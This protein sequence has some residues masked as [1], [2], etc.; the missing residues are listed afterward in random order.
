[1]YSFKTMAFLANPSLAEIVHQSN[2]SIDALSKSGTT[3][4]ALVTFIFWIEISE[5]QVK[6]VSFWKILIFDLDT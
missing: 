2:N 1:M 4:S 5:G 3:P 6:N